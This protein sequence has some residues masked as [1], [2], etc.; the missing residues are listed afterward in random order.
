VSIDRR[1]YHLK[2]RA[3]R[4]QQ[5]RDRIVRATVDL[6]REVGP[7]R[8]TVADIARRAGVQRLTVYNNFPALGDL[9]GACQHSFLTNNPPPN[10]AP[11]GSRGA[12]TLLEEA[13]VN[14]Y[15][16]YRGN[17]AMQRN[18]HRDRRLVVELDE[19]MRKNADPPLEAAARAYS[20]LIGAGPNS[21]M[22]V[23]SLVRLALEFTTW[24]I[25]AERGLADGEIAKLM[26]RAVAGVARQP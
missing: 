25:L 19:L 6:H 21:T 17:A 22:A 16:W 7:A 18:V 4:Q 5:T 15:R 26:G 10:I 1:K 12:L 14:L 11:V 24:E 9:L 13:L 20:E 23:R 8:T 3:D 2:A